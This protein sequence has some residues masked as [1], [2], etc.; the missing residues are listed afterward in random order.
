L[1]SP[2]SPL[3]FLSFQRAG[4]WYFD[5]ATRLEISRDALKSQ[6]DNTPFPGLELPGRVRQT[7]IDGTPAY[8]S[9]LS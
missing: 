8:D 1:R 2:E 5:P 9:G 3:D 7:L 4:I 6:G